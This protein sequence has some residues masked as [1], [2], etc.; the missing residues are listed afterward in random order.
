VRWKENP[1]AIAAPVV[2]VLL[3]KNALKVVR[4]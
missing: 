4:D 2:N 3:A 1:R